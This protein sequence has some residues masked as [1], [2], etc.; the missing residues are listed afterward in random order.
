MPRAVI[1]KEV[2]PALQSLTIDHMGV[3]PDPY[4]SVAPL[5]SLSDVPKITHLAIKGARQTEA[6]LLAFVERYGKKLESVTL[7]R[8]AEDSYDLMLNV[9]RSISLKKLK[10]AHMTDY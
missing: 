2:F 6:T 3:M 10:I 9:L 4:V 5:P 7:H 1:T 8:V